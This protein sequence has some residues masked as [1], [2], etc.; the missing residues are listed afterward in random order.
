MAIDSKKIID[1]ECEL[2]SLRTLLG[3]GVNRNSG[4]EQK[5]KKGD[6][7]KYFKD[8]AVILYKCKNAGRYS[9]PDETNFKKISLRGNKNGE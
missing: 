7:M 9:I 5:Y 1:K 6:I 3:Q 4:V 8:D 2:R